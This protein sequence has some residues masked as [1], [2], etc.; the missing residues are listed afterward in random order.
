MTKAE[1][2]AVIEELKEKF[3][4]NNFFYITDAST[5]TVEQVNDFRGK[6]F[7]K[8]VEMR[9]IKNTLAIKA[10]QAAPDEKGSFG[11]ASGQTSGRDL[12]QF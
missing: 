6:C 8:D 1:K 5:L 10:L 9:V 7:E 11:L 2:T 4:Q 3:D 12:A